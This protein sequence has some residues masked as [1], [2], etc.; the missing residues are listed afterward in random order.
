MT[1]LSAFHFQASTSTAGR[2]GEEAARLALPIL[3]SKVPLK[4][5]TVVLQPEL[6]MRRSTERQR[7]ETAVFEMAS[8]GLS[9][10]TTKLT[11]RCPCQHK[12]TT[13]LAI[14]GHYPI[15]PWPARTIAAPLAF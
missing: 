11:R 2:I 12:S 8:H 5:E 1:I 14:S 15:W 4:P 6:I 13:C 9:M 10:P 3:N 7:S